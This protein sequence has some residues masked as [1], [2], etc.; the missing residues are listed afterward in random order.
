M[1][2]GVDAA[3]AAIGYVCGEIM[4]GITAL[5]SMEVPAEAVGDFAAFGHARQFLR[6]FGNW[7]GELTRD[8]DA[9]R[10]LQN[11]DAKEEKLEEAE[12]DMGTVDEVFTLAVAGVR[13][14]VEACGWLLERYPANGVTGKRL[15]F[16]LDRYIPFSPMPP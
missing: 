14:A 9:S 3:G 16:I 15:R 13:R 11:E 8:A 6:R 5:P 10:V 12:Q 4:Q 1:F 7:R 2:G